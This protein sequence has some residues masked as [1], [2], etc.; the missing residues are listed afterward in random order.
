MKVAILIGHYYPG[1]KGAELFAQ[2]LAEYLVRRGNEV[3]VITGWWDKELARSEVIN[4]VNVYRIRTLRLKHFSQI[5]L[6]SPMFL[7]L[8]TLDRIESYDVFHSVG[9][10]MV[11]YAGS[12]MKV[13]RKKP[14]IITIQG[15]TLVT[16]LGNGLAGFILRKLS[17]LSL[18]HASLVHAISRELASVAKRFGAEDILTVPNGVDMA[19][20]IPMGK[21]KARKKLDIPPGKSMVVCVARLVPVKGIDYLIR[22]IALL[23][24]LNNRI[25]LLVIGDGPQRSD[26]EKLA[27]ELGLRDKVKFLGALPHE[28]IPLY[29]NAADIFVQP[30]LHEG[31]GI[32]LIEAM[33]CGIPVVGTRVDGILD[34]IEDGENGFL[35]PPKDSEALAEAVKRLFADEDIRSRF[36]TKGLETV[37]DKFQWDDVLPK[38]EE[39]YHSL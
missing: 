1:V 22:A 19:E 26:L 28:Q 6:F 32:A 29:L 35:V 33:S 18:K 37:K 3:D 25:S 31:L 24:Q 17:R 39:V 9:E 13:L 30:S 2:R 14:H 20:F 21:E 16:G 23:S 34:I 11:A 36:I 15:T 27:S 8:L 4:G 10:T 38:I 5:T 12:A 7:K